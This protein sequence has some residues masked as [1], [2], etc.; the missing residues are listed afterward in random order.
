MDKKITLQ[1]SIRPSSRAA[2]RRL[3]PYLEEVLDE[4]LLASSGYKVNPENK[5][6][7]CSSEYETFGLGNENKT[8]G[9]S[10][11]RNFESPYTAVTRE[12][13]TPTCLQNAK[14]CPQKRPCGGEYGERRIKMR[15][16]A[17]NELSGNNGD[18]IPS[19]DRFKVWLTPTSRAEALLKP[20]LRPK[21]PDAVGQ[22][23][24]LGK[25]TPN[26]IERIAGPRTENAD[27]VREDHTCS[28]VN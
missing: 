5:A 11:G 10:E 28:P 4:D 16:E 8:G 14:L 26:E 25:S 23:K 18:Y 21:F 19:N 12:W 15:V 9:M 6:S 20:L 17:D 7:S 22:T 13:H 1:E 27:G 2:E 24:L 3:Q